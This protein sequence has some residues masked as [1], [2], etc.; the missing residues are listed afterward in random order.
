[1]TLRLFPI[2]L[3]LVPIYQTIP[4]NCPQIL[5]SAGVSEKFGN[6]VGHAIDLISV[7]ALRRF[8]PSVTEKNRVPTMNM[9]LT[10][11]AG[12]STLCP[13]FSRL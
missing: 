4:L 11:E 10:S 7:R 5:G 1:M 2:L 13:G 3:C 9:D 6:S 8:N 12:S